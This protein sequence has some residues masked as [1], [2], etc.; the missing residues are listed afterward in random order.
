M[1][2]VSEL[3]LDR[4]ATLTRAALVEGKKLVALEVDS[5]A[6]SP[7]LGARYVAKVV[8]ALPLLGAVE[9]SLGKTTAFM[10]AKNLK[11]GDVVL[12]EWIAPP[13]GDK[14][15]VVKRMAGEASGAPRL[16]QDGPE[17][18]ERLGADFPVHEDDF[19]LIDLN[20]QID[21]LV[22]R[23]V[24]LGTAGSLVFDR[25]EAAHV[26]DVNGTGKDLNQK[27]LVELARQIRLRNLGGVVLV[28]L[29][30]DKRK[31]PKGLVE[32]L[33][34][35]VKKDP[36]K[37]EVY[38]ITKLGLLELTRERRGWELSRLLA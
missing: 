9:V 18:V 35:A 4:T 16:L 28:D 8:R 30:G 37:V 31:L 15:A 12:A 11:A 20:S 14:L 36:C 1:A 34:E 10:K 5:A 7:R 33:R 32:I 2:T 22:E 29:A 25:T 17:A 3:W 24:P 6:C 38:G 19:E 27:A 26:V 13:V 23:T 21:A